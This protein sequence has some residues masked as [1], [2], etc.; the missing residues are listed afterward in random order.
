M[1]SLCLGF[2]RRAAGLVSRERTLSLR[3]RSEDG[4]LLPSPIFGNFD[5][6]CVAPRLGMAPPKDDDW[7]IKNLS[8]AQA[9]SWLSRGVS[10]C[11]EESEFICRG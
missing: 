5:G 3:S 9:G 6:M 7:M 2:G 4:S 1:D 10:S 8:R 11:V